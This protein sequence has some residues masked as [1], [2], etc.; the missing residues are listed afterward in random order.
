LWLPLFYRFLKSA[1]PQLTTIMAKL[2]AVVAFF[3]FVAVASATVAV[4][5]YSDSGCTDAVGHFQVSRSREIYSLLT[6]VFRA[7][8]I[9]F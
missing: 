1:Q 3:A 6:T 7:T 5:T 9:A 2:F 8:L 4:T